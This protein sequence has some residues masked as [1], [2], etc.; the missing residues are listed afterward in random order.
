[1]YIPYH[2]LPDNV[3]IWVYAAPRTFT[4]AELAHIEAAAPAFLNGWAAHGTPLQASFQVLE[5]QFV[6]LAV[7]EAAQTASGCSIDSSVGFIRTLEEQLAL[8]LTDRSLVYFL[9]DG[10]VVVYPLTQLKPLIEQG[11]LTSETQLINTLVSTKGE[12]EQKWLLPAGGSWLKR[13]FKKATA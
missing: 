7:N 6:V 3:R 8:S 13:Y 2:Q 11:M 12:L 5:Q 4:Q 9:V 1:M 10:A